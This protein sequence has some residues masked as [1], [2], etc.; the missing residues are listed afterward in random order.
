MEY[1]ARYGRL[2]GI[3]FQIQDDL[4]DITGD[5]TLAG[6]S[7]GTDLLQQ[8]PT[9]PII[10]ALAVADPQQRRHLHALLSGESNG[11]RDSL[12]KWFDRLDALDYTRRRGREFAQQALDCLDF[13]PTSPAEQ[14]L[15]KLGEFVVSRS[16]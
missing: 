9:L 12:C 16:H 3:A 10:R 8:K 11:Q 4:L 1:L 7:L 14:S 13:L 6:K 2:L 5:E 15:R